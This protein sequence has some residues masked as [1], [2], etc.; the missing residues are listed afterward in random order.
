MT[1]ATAEKTELKLSCREAKLVL[2]TM[3]LDK[4]YGEMAEQET[5]AYLHYLRCEECLKRGLAEIIRFQITCQEALEVLA[6]NPGPLHWHAST[7]RERIAAE[8]VFGRSI[9]DGHGYTDQYYGACANRACAPICTLWAHAPLCSHYDGEKE[10]ARQIPLTVELFVEA[11]WPLAKLLAIQ[12]ER[13]TTLLAAISKGG[14]SE[15][16]RAEGVTEVEAHLESLQN[17]LLKRTQ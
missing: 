2:K 11:G 9:K 6:Q 5:A 16:E 10:L 4:K 15:H 7:V 3:P 8:H 1:T 17:L 13:I 14:T 12:R